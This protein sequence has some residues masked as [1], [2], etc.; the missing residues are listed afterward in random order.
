M[1]VFTKRRLATAAAFVVGVALALPTA[2]S[3]ENLQVFE[4]E[5]DATQEGSPSPPTTFGPDDWNNIL[6]TMGKST[7][8]PAIASLVTT[9]TGGSGSFPGVIVHPSPGTVFTGGGSKDGIDITSWAWKNASPPPKDG[10]TDAYLAAYVLNEDISGTGNKAG[11]L[12]VYFG[13][14][15]G[16]TNGS[17]QLG[18]WLFQ[19]TIGLQ[20]LVGSSAGFTGTHTV[21]DIL[22]LINF[23][24]G[25]T[26]ATAQI[27][28]WVGSGGEI[29]G[30]LHAL[31]PAAGALCTPGT[32]TDDLFCAITNLSSTTAPWPYAGGATFPPQAFFEGGVNL[33]RVFRDLLNNKP[34][35]CIT[36]F[37]TE[38]RS[39]AGN[40][41]DPNAVLKAFVLGPFK[42]CDFD[43]TKNCTSGKVN[44]DQTAFTWTYSGTVH[45]KGGGSLF[46]VTVFDTPTGG[47]E[48]QVA[49]LGTIAAGAT[50]TYGPLT[51]DSTANPA[52]DT[53]EVTAAGVEGGVVILDKTKFAKCTQISI[54]PNL[55]VNKTCDPTDMTFGGPQFSTLGS[56]LD[57]VNG[58]LVI[59]VKVNAHVCNKGTVNLINV[60]VNDDDGTGNPTQETLSPDVALP[61]INGMATLAVNKCA[62]YTHTYTVTDS[63]LTLPAKASSIKLHDTVQG[64][65]DQVLGLGSTGEV[66]SGPIDCPLCF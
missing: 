34:L 55:A 11:D 18:V 17:A 37:L 2:W 35:P 30:T 51:Y 10:I 19:Q 54:S 38:S 57:L 59:K 61:I 40:G 13:Q 64:S 20:P 66:K 41:I 22:I 9:S 65:A 52:S 7:V 56:F 31:T 42:V 4:L 25:G 36:T 44:A 45:N 26:V 62:D 39:S 23:S 33:T 53:V 60:V 43:L 14:D 29:L 32:F 15:R 16:A 48:T 21:G 63:E 46:D 28:E 8:N 58:A 6:V 12:L 27:L 50:V 47:S 24:G 5:G 1:T 49:S 3:V